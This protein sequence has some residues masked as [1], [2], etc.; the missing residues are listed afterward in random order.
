MNAL[1]KVICMAAAL[2]LIASL[3]A[4]GAKNEMP[5]PAEQTENNIDQ[6]VDLMDT[7]L[8]DEIMEDNTPAGEKYESDA[9]IPYA[10]TA[11]VKDSFLD[12]ADDNQTMF[13]TK[14]GQLLHSQTLESGFWFAGRE[15]VQQVV[16]A[17]ND[18]AYT[19]SKGFLYIYDDNHIFPCQDIKGQVVWYFQDFMTGNLCVI[20]QDADGYLYYNM[21]AETGVKEKYDNEKLCIYDFRTETYYDR[22]DVIRFVVD[23][24]QPNVYVEV[25]GKAFYSNVTG[26]DFFGQG[27][28]IWVDS[29]YATSVEA[30]YAYGYGAAQSTLH[31]VEGDENALYYRYGY[32]E[33]ELPVF[34]PQGKTVSQLTQVVFG[35][36]TI[37]LFDD[38]TVYTC[39]LD[40]T[41]VGVEPVLD[42]T[43]TALN[44]GG[45]ICKIYQSTFLRDRSCEIRILLDDNVTYVYASVNG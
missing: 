12:F 42:E 32:S 8:Q 18:P 37:L 6:F 22:V 4:C 34:M 1:K 20:S 19:D 44:Q 16:T 2:M 31:S 35:E 33:N 27:P 23:D 17:W 40:H 9:L 7:H 14:D 10:A 5:A 43:L 45:A 15:D 41:V 13:W 11:Q 39:L 36:T 26:I 25:D 30:V 28:Q 21:V 3:C 38:G 29:A 24:I